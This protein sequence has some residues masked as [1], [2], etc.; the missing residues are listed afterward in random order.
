[1]AAEIKKVI[2][3]KESS[4]FLLTND[5]ASGG[6]SAITKVDISTLPGA[7]TRVKVNRLCWSLRD[8]SAVLYYDR[9][10]AIRI[11][12]LSGDGELDLP[13]G[14]EDTGSGGTGDIKLTTVGASTNSTYTIVLGFKADA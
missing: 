8:L 7:P 10:S 4:V 12:V 13:E 11:A 1:M 6:E 5:A 2:E 9:S 3:N 14:I